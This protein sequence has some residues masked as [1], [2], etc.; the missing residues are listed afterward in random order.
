MN[1][2]AHFAL[3]L[4]LA[5]PTTRVAF[6]GSGTLDPDN[7]GARRFG[8]RGGRYTSARQ[9]AAGESDPAANAAQIGRDRYATSKLLN[10]LTVQALAKRGL[11]A[12]A[13]DPGLMPGTGLARNYSAV[14]RF[15]W[16]TRVAAL[17][18]RGASTPKRSGEALAH[19]MTSEITRGGYYEFTRKPMALPAVAQNAAHAEELYLASLALA[20]FA[21]DPLAARS[22]A[23]I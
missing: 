15:A 14:M 13:F 19:Y 10:L 20:G 1:H 16:N 5:S 18:M 4:H 12:F 9:L 8:F 3:V 23:A 7:T 17:F 21:A 2:L 22:N 11:D 6:I